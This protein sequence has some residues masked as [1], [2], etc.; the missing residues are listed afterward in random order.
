M[1]KLIILLCL[2]S[3]ISHAEDAPIAPQPVEK[4]IE[5]DP[6][7]IVE[8]ENKI[9]DPLFKNMMVVQKKVI[10]KSNKFFI[11][12]N[13]SF[14]Y[15]DSPKS[16][17]NLNLGVGYALS[18]SIEIGLS[19]SPLFLVATKSLYNEASKLVS[20]QFSANDPKS[21]IGVHVN[22]QLAYGK[23]AFGL[24]SISRSET[25]LK[26]FLNQTSF[27]NSKS[28]SQ[29]GIGLGKTYFISK[30]I[31]F[32]FCVSYAHTNYFINDES[33]STNSALIEPGLVL[34]F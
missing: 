30:Y 29:M 9:S 12:T 16:L 14:D 31:N 26:M 32:R 10:T 33:V 21:Q 25:F 19:F 7:I 3:G 6:K 4:K 5:L 20:G 11:D 1:K 24:F 23:D 34:F 8:E 13:L 15:S 2:C 18:D 22:Y 28:G 27:E 17:H